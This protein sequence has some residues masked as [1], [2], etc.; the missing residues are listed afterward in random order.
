MDVLLS[1]DVRKASQRQWAEIEESG[2]GLWGCL[3][4]SLLPEG[5]QVRGPRSRGVSRYH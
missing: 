1:K 3:E 4:K 5:Q 2:P